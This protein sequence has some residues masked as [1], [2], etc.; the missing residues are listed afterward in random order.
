MHILITV[1]NDISVPL[2]EREESVCFVS[3]E[4]DLEYMFPYTTLTK[5]G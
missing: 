2:R 1:T 5:V 4:K 3:W